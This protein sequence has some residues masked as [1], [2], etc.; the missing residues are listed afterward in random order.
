MSIEKNILQNALTKAFDD[1]IAAFSAFDE[2]TIN[3]KPNPETWTPVQV[4]VHIIMATDGVPDRS[5]RAAD[6]EADQLLPSI[7]P[8]WE[9]LN[10]RFTSPDALEPDEQ[11]RTKTEILTDLNRVRN[12]D[13]NIIQTRDLTAVCLDLE[14]PT[15]GFLTRYE[16]L[17]FIQMHL[18]RHTYQLVNMKKAW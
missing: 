15:I 9:D 14:L 8:W 10:Q 2:R 16:W 1:F 4:A 18:R 13:L 17:W 11:P 3:H 12:K 5:T 7:R 6:R